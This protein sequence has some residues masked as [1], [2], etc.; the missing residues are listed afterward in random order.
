MRYPVCFIWCLKCWLCLT[1]RE[2]STH[3][4][5][6]LYKEVRQYYLNCRP[7]LL[8]KVT[9]LE[10]SLFCGRTNKQPPPPPSTKF[11]SS[12]LH[13]TSSK[14]VWL[15]WSY[16][17]YIQQIY[18]SW[19]PDY[20]ICRVY[21]HDNISPAIVVRQSI[22]RKI[23]DQIHTQECL[24]AWQTRRRNL[25][26]YLPARVGGCIVPR[27]S[28]TAARNRMLVAIRISGALEMVA[29]PL[30]HWTI[31]QSAT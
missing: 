16:E 20:L 28:C 2:S 31:H 6:S 25:P 23:L 18:L 4:K 14:R 5:R 19:L 21:S 13:R 9:I 26:M 8:I 10:H 22:G 27:A 17:H 3:L 11:L 7:S 24:T 1:W 30:G 15:R 29:V 12:R